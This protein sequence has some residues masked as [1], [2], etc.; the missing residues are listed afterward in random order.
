M[1]LSAPAWAAGENY[2]ID[3]VHSDVIFRASHLGVSHAFGR[4]NEIS[5]EIQV[6]TDDPAKM[7]I[8]VEIQTGSL[9]TNSDDRDKHLRSPD[10]FNAKQFPL[11]QFK[12][13]AVRSKGGNKLEMTGDLTLHGVTKPVTV[14]VEK[15]GAGKDPW[16]GYRAGWV[17]EFTI[18]RSDFGMK[19]MLEGLG[20]EVEIIVALEG[21]RE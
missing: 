1:G 10:F 8:N 9:D 16:G 18:K 5:G 21:V 7:T 4:F 19:F 15:V 14:E 20:D 3:N 13:T 11:I 6:D 17:S 2:A 12:S